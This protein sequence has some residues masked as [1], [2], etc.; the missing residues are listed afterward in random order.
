MFEESYYLDDLAKEW[1]ESIDIFIFGEGTDERILYIP[2]KLFPI[3]NG[4]AFRIS[5]DVMTEGCTISK[6]KSIESIEYDV[7]NGDITIGLSS[8]LRKIEVMGKRVL[9]DITGMKHPAFFFLFK[10]LFEEQKPSSLFAG[11]SEPAKY[12]P[13]GS[14]EVEERFQLFEG[15]LGVRALPGFTRLPNALVSKLLVAFLGFEGTRLQ[16]VYDDQEPGENNTVA[17]VGFP[18]FRPGWQNLT[19]AA[20]EPA[21]QSTS[22]YRFMRTATAFSPFD[23]YHIL[24]DLQSDRPEQNLVVAPIGTRPHALGAVIYAI[25]NSNSYLLY[26]FPIEVSEHRTE[27][28]G[29]CHIYHLSSFL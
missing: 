17:V 3:L 25:K 14:T 27:K 2:Q 7:Y 23:A 5:Y 21:L 20:N 29:K 24:C 28:I 11:Y 18:A 19:I 16:H 9:I 6:M 12:V 1:L 15:Y 26:D 10:L 22:S 8:V 13:H 4:V